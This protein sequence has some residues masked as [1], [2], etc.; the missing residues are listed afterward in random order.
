MSFFSK[1]T[2]FHKSSFVDFK[3]LFLNNVLKVFLFPLF[4]FSGYSVSVGLHKSLSELF[5][6]FEGFL[7]S[8]FS[9]AVLATLLAF[10]LGD[11]LRF[12][13]H[14]LMHRFKP[15]FKIHRTHHSATVLTPFTLFRTHPLESLLGSIRSILS[16]GLTLGLYSFLFQGKV[17]AIDILGVNAFGFLFNSMFANLRHSSVPLSFGPLEYLFISPRMHQIHHS[18]DSKHFNKNFGV[19]LSIWDMMMGSFYRPSVGEA[20]QLKFGLIDSDAASFSEALL[21]DFRSLQNGFF[22]FKRFSKS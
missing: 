3:L 22:S 18:L 12:F 21:P 15:L 5:P 11:F 2:L 14:Y 9:R 20:K 4:L 17:S 16:L 13:Q 6:G 10:V 7:I 1:K 8:D 19:A